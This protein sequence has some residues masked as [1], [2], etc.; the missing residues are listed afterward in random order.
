MSKNKIGYAKPPEPKF[1]REMKAKLGYREPAD[2]LEDKLR[3]DAGDFDD[4]E[5]REDEAPTVVVMKDGDLTQEQFKEEQ[6]LMEKLEEDKKVQEGKIAFKKPVKKRESSDKDVSE[7]PSIK[8][9]K[10]HDTKKNDS[11]KSKKN[12]CL[13]SFNEDEEDE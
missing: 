7:E 9:D 4:R 3:G 6:S 11:K 2:N 12:N 8:K 10:K 5:D 1:I 13:L